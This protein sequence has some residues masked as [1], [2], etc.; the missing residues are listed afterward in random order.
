MKNVFVEIEFV[1]NDNNII[2]KDDIIIEEV[3]LKIIE[4]YVKYINATI[5]E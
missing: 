2:K 5:I 3:Y 1:D 4:Q